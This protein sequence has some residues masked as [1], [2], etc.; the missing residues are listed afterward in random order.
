MLENMHRVAMF[1]G[2][3]MRKLPILKTKDSIEIIA[4]ASRIKNEQLNDLVKLVESWGLNCIVEK[5]IFGEDLLCANSDAARFRHLEKSFLRKETKAIL[6]ARGGYGSMKLLPAL[7]KISAPSHP[8][9]FIGM[10]DITALTLFLEQKWSWPS[11]HGAAALDKFSPESIEALRSI[12]FGEKPQLEYFGIPMNSL[13]K[14]SEML[15]AVFTGG[16]LCLVQT[17]IGT[18]WQI[19]GKNKII[20]LEDTGERG[21]RIDRMLE[22]L[23]QADIFKHAKAIVFGDFVEGLEPDGRSLVMPVLERF[24]NRLHIPAVQIS[25]IGHGFTNIPIPLGVEASLHLGEKTKLTFLR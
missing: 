14:N 21:Y 1:I 8:K 25:G 20:F 16:N 4:P 9:L 6:S 5:D 24:A 2:K 13:A 23:S 11:L 17:S 22:H 3:G 10:S 19:E 12:M 18:I 7:S 15:S